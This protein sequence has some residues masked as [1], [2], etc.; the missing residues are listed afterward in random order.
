MCFPS[1]EFLKKLFEVALQ[2]FSIDEAKQ[3]QGNKRNKERNGN[4]IPQNGRI[5]RIVFLR[6]KALRRK[7]RTEPIE[8]GEG[9]RGV[10]DPERIDLI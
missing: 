6:Q 1:T 3:E 8:H 5:K 10:H 4:R 9:S 2:S 7:R